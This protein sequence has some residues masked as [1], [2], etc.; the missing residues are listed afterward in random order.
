MQ[1]DSQEQKNLVISALSA[2]SVP[3]GNRS[4]IDPLVEQLVGGKVVA[5][6]KESKDKAKVKMNE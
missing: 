6:K 2:Y 4:V 1:Y 5:V 3:L